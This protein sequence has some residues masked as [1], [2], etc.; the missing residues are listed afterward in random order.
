MKHLCRNLGQFFQFFQI[1]WSVFICHPAKIEDSKI[2]FVINS[3][4]VNRVG[5]SGDFVVK[6]AAGDAVGVGVDGGWLAQSGTRPQQQQREARRLGVHVG[7]R[8]A[9][10][11][12]WSGWVSLCVCVC[13]HRVASR[14][15]LKGALLP[16][17][18][19]S[20][21]PRGPAAGPGEEGRAA[22]RGAPTHCI[23]NR[24][25]ST[26]YAASVLSL[27]CIYVDFDVLLCLFSHI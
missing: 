8:K 11:W 1:I 13:V 19:L 6:A 21:S 22:G 25:P 9:I 5:R 24:S 14:G 26:F 18:I 10:D 4:L 2:N 20:D 7:E 27:T 16:A 3:Y 12:F 17:I 23:I 15:S